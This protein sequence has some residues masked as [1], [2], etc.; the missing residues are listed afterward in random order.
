MENFLILIAIIFFCFFVV[1]FFSVIE[2]FWEWLDQKNGFIYRVIEFL[3]S[4]P[5]IIIFAAVIGYSI[6]S[7]LSFYNVF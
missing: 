5:V 7:Y 6:Y 3:V 4:L 1:G 2:M